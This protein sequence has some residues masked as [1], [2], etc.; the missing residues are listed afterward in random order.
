MAQPARLSQLSA[1]LRQSP[2]HIRHHL[3]LLEEA[4]PQNAGPVEVIG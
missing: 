1:A 4:G 2:A 3:K